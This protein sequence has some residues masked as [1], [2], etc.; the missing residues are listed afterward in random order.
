MDH[1]S[2][3]RQQTDWHNTTVKVCRL[4]VTFRAIPRQTNPLPASDT[5]LRGDPFRDENST[6]FYWQ[7]GSEDGQEHAWGLCCFRTQHTLTIKPN[8]PQNPAVIALATGVRQ[9][10]FADP[11]H[12]C[13]SRSLFKIVTDR[14]ECMTRCLNRVRLRR[15]VNQSLVSVVRLTHKIFDQRLKRCD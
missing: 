6:V 14:Y 1:L 9:A 5:F 4:A 2:D 8:R 7:A 12:P 13:G 10:A 3:N 11:T 15:C